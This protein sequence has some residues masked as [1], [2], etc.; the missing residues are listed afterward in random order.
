MKIRSARFD[1]ERRRY[2]LIFTCEDCAHFVPDSGAFDGARTFGEQVRHLGTVL[3]LSAVVLTGSGPP[4]PPGKANNGPEAVQGR[5]ATIRFLRDSFTVARESI[6]TLT[7]ANHM[8]KVQSLFGPVPRSSIAVSLL[9]HSYNHYG[10]MTVY[11][12]L[13]GIVPP[14]SVEHERGRGDFR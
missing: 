4:F 8:A 10:Q 6:Q 14:G 3:Q 2:Q 11:A 9:A 13:N 5:D 1:E 7:D 12:R